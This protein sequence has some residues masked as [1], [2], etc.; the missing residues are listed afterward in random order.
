M[1][2]FISHQKGRKVAEEMDVREKKKVE[3]VP[4]IPPVLNVLYSQG[5]GRRP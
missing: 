1:G 3:L 5:P 4:N 2:S